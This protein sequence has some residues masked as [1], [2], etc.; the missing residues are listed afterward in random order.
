VSADVTICWDVADAG[1]VLDSWSHHR[2]VKDVRV[3]DWVRERLPGLASGTTYFYRFFATNTTV[4]LS[5]WSDV[6]SFTTRSGPVVSPRPFVGAIRWDAW[7]GNEYE[8]GRAV[9]RSL[10]PAHWHYRL[11]Y[12]GRVVAS[13]Q[14]EVRSLTQADADKQIAFAQ[15]AGLD[16]WAF[17]MYGTNDPMTR[18][19]L[20]R[21]L[22]SH[23]RDDMKFCM[24][25][26]PGHPSVWPETLTRLVGYFQLPNYMRVLGERPLLFWLTHPNMQ[27]TRPFWSQLWGLASTASVPKPYVVVLHGDP[28]AAERLQLDLGLD[29]ISTYAV[30]GGHVAAAYPNL[31]GVAQDWWH[32]AS[33]LG[34]RLV[35]LASVG[36][37]RR[38][39]VENPVPW[40]D[41]QPG[42]GI[43]YYYVAPTPSEWTDHLRTAINW[44]RSHPDHTPADTILIYAWNELDEGGYLL[45]THVEG[46][47]RLSATQTALEAPA[48]VDGDALDDLWEIWFF[49]QTGRSDGGQADQD[50]DGFPDVSEYLANTDPTDPKSLLQIER[51]EMKMNGETLL[52]WQS[53]SN[54]G[55]TIQCTTRLRSSWTNL[56][57]SLPATPPLNLYTDRTA[58]VHTKVYRLKVD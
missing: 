57:V 56:E 19:G 18:F 8:V 33:A 2:F 1:T 51:I 55:Y 20:D 25:L 32:Q 46:T 3:G 5:S 26:D 10:G 4:G 37:D 34:A 7:I 53:V 39:R 24:I 42:V 30:N 44:V 31:A 17:C 15:A 43:E 38:P 36:W 27:E 35:P 49:D 12:F 48:D 52:G 6:K 9:E 14:V 40:E 13:D 58:L 41:Q 29:A 16:Y 54:R 21:Y 45:P 22:S 47:A 28:R 11:P 50:A 23:H